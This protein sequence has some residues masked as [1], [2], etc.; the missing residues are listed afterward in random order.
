MRKYLLATVASLTCVTAASPALA[1]DGSGYVG[2]DIGIVWPKSHDVEGGIDFTNPAVADIPFHRIGSLDYKAGVD[3]DI[4]GGYDFGLFRL[5]GELGY[6]HGNVNNLNV[7]SA[8][9]GAINSEG[10]INIGDSDLGIDTK[11]N[12]WSA[13]VNGW[14]DLGGNTGFGGGIGGGVGYAGV[15]EF[16]SSH[17]SFAWQLLAQAYYPVSDQIDIGLKYR[18]FH[19]GKNNGTDSFTFATPTACTLPLPATCSGGVATLGDNARFVSHSILLSFVYNFA[20]PAP[21]PP[22]PVERGERGY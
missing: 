7:D 16:G 11:S 18:F 4:V 6:K 13:M 17:S 8:F 20:A 14:L 5:E 12:A 2:A 19:A 15:H 10:N 1:K 9:L 3:A 22:P 21:P